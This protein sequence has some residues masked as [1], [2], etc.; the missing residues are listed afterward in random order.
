MR[1]IATLLALSCATTAVAQTA[2]PR[3]MVSQGCR[4]EIMNLCPP[5]GD[6]GARRE[7]MMAAR[8]KLSEG[9]AKELIALR[10]ARQGV[11][12]GGNGDMAAPGAMTA[13]PQP[14]PQP[15]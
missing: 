10:A 5:T 12:M 3:P 8:G 13:D 9:C 4:T 14:V 7:C 2:A 15:Q 1:R 6:R 11:R